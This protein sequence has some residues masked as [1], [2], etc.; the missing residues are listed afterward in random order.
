MTHLG[1]PEAALVIP[2]GAGSGW[3]CWGTSE[4]VRLNDHIKTKT[5]KVL[6]FEAGACKI[7]FTFILLLFRGLKIP[8][9]HTHAVNARRLQASER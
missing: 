9:T 1:I 6:G 7:E 3:P 2:G 4:E 5:S 8:P